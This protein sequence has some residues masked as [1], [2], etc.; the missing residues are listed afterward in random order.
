[1]VAVANRR[2]REFLLFIELIT[3]CGWFID[4][5]GAHYEDARNGGIPK[6][7]FL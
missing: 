1:M 7:L 5:K 6:A 3:W 2:M 4:K